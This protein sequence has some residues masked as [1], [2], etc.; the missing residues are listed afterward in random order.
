MQ[1]KINIPYATRPPNNNSF[2]SPPHP[3]KCTPKQTSLGRDY[4]SLKQRHRFSYTE[5]FWPCLTGAINK[6]RKSQLYAVS[7]RSKLHIWIQLDFKFKPRPIKETRPSIS[8]H[9]HKSMHFRDQHCCP[10][11]CLE[12]ISRTCFPHNTA[13]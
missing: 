10:A 13:F 12:I 7:Y 1:T 9:C 2:F 6:E 4:F 5:S 11:M 3:N 8:R